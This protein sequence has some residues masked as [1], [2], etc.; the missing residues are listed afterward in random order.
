V[1]AKARQSA[2]PLPVWLRIDA[3][4]GFF[5]VTEWPALDWP[6]QV[7]R[8]ATTLQHDLADAGAEH[9]AGVLLSS[10]SA[11]APGATNLT[12]ENETVHTERG[13]GIR[14]LL[15]DH[16]VRETAVIPLRDDATAEQARWTAAYSTEPDW[17]REDLSSRAFPQ[18]EAILASE[19]AG[20]R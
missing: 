10:S 15:A 9:L 8:V 12:A 11:E 5:Q 20:A 1:H 7:T 13:S 18:L 4:D 16:I 14:R 17:L 19:P 3:L 2:G 6:E